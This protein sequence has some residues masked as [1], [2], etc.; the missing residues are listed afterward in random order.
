MGFCK[1]CGRPRAGDVRFC[2][3]CGTEFTAVTAAGETQPAAVPLA[4]DEGFRPP[5]EPTDRW[6]TEDTVYAAPGYVPP[7]PPGPGFPPPSGPAGPRR[8]SGGG[9]TAALVIVAIVVALAVGGGVYALVSGSHGHATAQPSSNPTVSVSV[10]TVPAVQA[11]ASLAQSASAAPSATPSASVTPGP[12]QT[13]TVQVASDAV[14]D[15]GEPQV[16]A[17]LN[18]YFNAIN[19]RNYGEYDSLLDAQERQ[20]NS[21][22]SFDSGYATTKDSNEVLTGIANTGGG[23]L[24][25]SVSFTSHQSPA[26]SID[27]SACDDWQLSLFLARQ[28]NGYVMTAAPAGYHALYADC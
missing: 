25:V 23:D 18:S 24:T 26:D 7:A 6:K 21:R 5:D 1:K 20:A 3:G 8:R 28:G 13:G 27:D 16:E 14:G 9:R 11:S 12:T 19:T 22:S 10:G 15:Q 17:F 2:P 4:G